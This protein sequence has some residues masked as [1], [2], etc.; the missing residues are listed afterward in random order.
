M[1]SIDE[2]T[3]RDTVAMNYVHVD[4][5]NQQSNVDNQQ[6]IGYRWLSDDQ[7]QSDIESTDEQVGGIGSENV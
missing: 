1:M 4:A 3:T 6:L 2:L 7:R 5:A